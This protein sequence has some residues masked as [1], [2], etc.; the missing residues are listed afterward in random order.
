ML[1]IVIAADLSD[2]TMAGSQAGHPGWQKP[3]PLPR[4]PPTPAGRGAG[5]FKILYQEVAPQALTPLLPY[6]LLPRAPRPGVHTYPGRHRSG[7]FKILYQEVAPQALKPWL[8]LLHHAGPE[9]DES[10]A[11]ARNAP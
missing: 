2:A 11:V 4:P 6:A 5:R 7:R 9:E 10:E 3:S 8:K 1:L